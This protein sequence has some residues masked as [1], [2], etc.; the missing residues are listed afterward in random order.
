MPNLD[1]LFKSYRLNALNL[2]NRIVMAPMTRSMSPG[3]I[4]TAEVAGYYRRRALS[5][6]FRTGC[7]GG[8]KRGLVASIVT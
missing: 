1:V 6:A 8:A 5:L 2:P 4:P 3:G 7:I